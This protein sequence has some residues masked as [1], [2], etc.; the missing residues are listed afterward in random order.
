MRTETV[1]DVIKLFDNA[2][3]MVAYHD[4]LC[5]DLIAEG[6]SRIVY[7]CAYD[8]TC[9]VKISKDID[10]LASDNVLEWE[11]WQ[12][13]KSMTNDVPKWFAPCVKISDNGRILIQ[14]KTKPLTDKQWENLKG[15]PRFLSDVK[16]SNFGMYKGHVCSHDYAFTLFRLNMDKRMMKISKQDKKR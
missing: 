15:V 14:K 8:D 3:T 7:E 1:K 2:E 10:R 12:M 6:C 9:V 5:G 11:I 13:V 16:R 4:L